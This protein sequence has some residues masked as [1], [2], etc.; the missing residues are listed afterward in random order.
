MSPIL[1]RAVE[2]ATGETILQLRGRSLEDTRRVA[3]QRNRRPLKFISKF[4]FIGRGN[5][6]RDRLVTHDAVE[7]SLDEA[8]RD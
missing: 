6:M 5:V 1:Q 7:A 4:P 8:L 2:K 3:E